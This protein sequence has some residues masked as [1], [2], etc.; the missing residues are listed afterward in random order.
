MNLLRLLAWPLSLIYGLAVIIRNKLFDFGFIPST[1]IN[2]IALIGVGNLT[3]GGTG[4]TPHVEYLVKLLHPKYKVG[5]LSRGYGR[6]TI[7][8]HLATKD[9]TT[10]EIGDEPKQFRHRFPDEIPVAVDGQR[11]HGVK[12]LIQKFPSLQ[13]VILDD[14]FQHRRIKPG[15]QIMLTDYGRLFYQDNL[16]PTGYLR[17]PKSGV[18]RA[19]II[20]VTKTPDFFSPLERKRIIKEIKAQPYQKIYF[21]KIIYGDFVPFSNLPANEIVTKEICFGK[22]YSV[23]LLT[24][25]ANSHSLEYFLKD[26]VKELV[27][28]RFR[29]HHEFMPADLLRLQEIFREMKGDKKIVLTTEKDAMRLQKPGLAEYLGDLPVYYVPIEVAFQDQDA[30]DFN[31]QINEYVRPHPANRNLH[32][33]EN[34]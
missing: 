12:K 25:I 21:S 9:A 8:F 7:G 29:D 11:V 30:I 5:T 33:R 26:K 14:V 16:L 10:L 2:D 3:V 27:P 28:F 23:V 15:L 32:K 1:E 13:V 17:E 22:G 4:K 31:Q 24:G 34:E 20:V 19:D 6:K 18:R